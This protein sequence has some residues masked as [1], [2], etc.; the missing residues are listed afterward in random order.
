[1]I[2]AVLILNIA[3]KSLKAIH[4]NY[5]YN[6]FVCIEIQD[7]L[8]NLEF[9]KFYPTKINVRKVISTSDKVWVRYRLG[10][11]YKMLLF[12]G[13]KFLV[14]YAYVSGICLKH[15]TLI[16]LLSSLR[17]SMQFQKTLGEYLYQSNC[18]ILLLPR[19]RSRKEFGFILI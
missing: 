15:S 3:H 6:F 5:V 12:N 18:R 8:E 1:M 11:I 13:R 4:V 2:Q 7:K 10:S 9:E 14:L 16:Q 17:N 19:T